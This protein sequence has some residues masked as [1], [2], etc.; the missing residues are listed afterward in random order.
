MRFGRP[1]P[2]SESP[3]S[4]QTTLRLREAGGRG[5]AE[6]DIRWRARVG[7]ADDVAA[8]DVYSHS[9]TS[10]MTSDGSRPTLPDLS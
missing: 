3:H 8:D 1:R 4:N 10:M 6:R 9:S 5:P 7:D 2:R